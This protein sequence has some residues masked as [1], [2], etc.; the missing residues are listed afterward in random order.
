MHC[1]GRCVDYKA[2]S[3]TLEGGR[4]EQGQKRCHQCELFMKWDGLWCPCC[5]HL[6]RTKPRATKP[7]RRLSLMQKNR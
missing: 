4:Y 2:T 6:L 5:G 7:K 1:V 3:N